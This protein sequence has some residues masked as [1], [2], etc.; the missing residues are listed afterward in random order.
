MSDCRD[1][2]EESSVASTDD[3]EEAGVVDE[4]VSTSA[5]VGEAVSADCIGTNVAMVEV[6]VGMDGLEVLDVD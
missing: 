5:D 2:F 1:V 6:A 4:S 3:E